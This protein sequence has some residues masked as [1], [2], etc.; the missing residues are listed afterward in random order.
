MITWGTPR[1]F[2]DGMPVRGVGTAR[3]WSG[4]WGEESRAERAGTT[5]CF[6]GGLV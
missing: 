4:M 2:K 1:P 3:V 6:E 5:R